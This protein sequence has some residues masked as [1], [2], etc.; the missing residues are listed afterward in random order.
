MLAE[1]D[2][3][4]DGILFNRGEILPDSNFEPPKPPTPPPA[5]TSAQSAP[6]LSASC[7]AGL[8][9]RI[10]AQM[11]ALKRNNQC[12]I[13]E[14]NHIK[15]KYDNLTDSFS[16]AGGGKYSKKTKQNKKITK[17]LR[18]KH[19]RKS[20]KRKTFNRKKYFKKNRSRK[21]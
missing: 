7:A 19:K 9:R 4:A 6:S 11:E 1:E 8:K 13:D 15:P 16:Q 17:K 21:N 2:T 18:K 14:Y 5:T 12:T 3:W 20:K 10:K